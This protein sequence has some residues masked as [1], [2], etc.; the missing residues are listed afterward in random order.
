MPLMQR[1]SANGILALLLAMLVL[2]GEEAHARAGGGGGGRGGG[3]LV[4]IL[5]PLLLVYAGIVTWLLRRKSREA[6][7]ALALAAR[8]KAWDPDELKARIEQVFFKVQNAWTLRNQ[9]LARDCMSE[10]LYRKHKLQ[11]DQMI[12]DGTRNILECVNLSKATI[13]EIADFRDN[14]KDRLWACMEG[15]MI[16]YHIRLSTGAVAKGSKDKPEDFSELWKFIRT[17]QGWVLDEIDQ[18]V[19]LSDL[20]GFKSIVE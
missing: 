4:V 18:S 6:R 11:T 16:D 8:D 17:P 14:A 10:R 1:L 5:Y 9:D 3:G 20:M 15:S 12:Q 7:A 19:D 13:V 2:A